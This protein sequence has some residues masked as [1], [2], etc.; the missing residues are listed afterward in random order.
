MEPSLLLQ[1]KGCA[2]IIGWTEP[3]P[4][5]T[6]LV[7][8]TLLKNL[9]P[10]SPTLSSTSS[11]IDLDKSS[12][13]STSDYSPTVSSIC[14]EPIYL[15]TNKKVLNNNDDVD[16]NLKRHTVEK[17]P[18]PEGVKFIGISDDSICS[19]DDDYD[20]DEKEDNDDKLPKIPDGGWGWMVVLSS[21]VLS[22]IAD[23]ISFSF[24]LIYIEFLD[25]FGESKSK[26]SWIGSLFLSVP[27]MSGPI[28]SALVDKYGCRNITM[29]GGLISCIG[30]VL[31][32]FSNSIEMLLLNFGIIAGFGLG[33]CYVTCV[34]SIAYWFDKKRTLA[35]GLGAC[36]TGVGTFIYAPMTRYFIESFGWRGTILLLA[37]TLL[38]MCVCGAIMRD[39]EWWILEQ[40]KQLSQSNKSMRGAS[41]CGSVSRISGGAESTFLNPDELKDLIRS[42]ETPEYILTTLATSIAAGQNEG[43]PKQDQEQLCTSVINLPTFLK[44]SEKVNI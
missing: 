43:K 40:K 19:K 25:H 31:S 33:M 32:S 14:D 29:L 39:P 34:V 5:N 6:P 16:E 27:L 36:G 42:G 7:E 11:G 10:S 9:T 13:K 17:N 30:F 2:P 20:S 1:R 44:Q 23:G 28:M 3:S 21:F 35:V 12:F 26:T 18:T 22:A 15:S 38:N 4:T 8:K 24:G 37:G 41:S